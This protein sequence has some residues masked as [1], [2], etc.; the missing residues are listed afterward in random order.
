MTQIE[1]YTGVDEIVAQQFDWNSPSPNVVRA[2]LLDS[3]SS[4]ASEDTVANLAAFTTLGEYAGSPSRT[5]LADLNVVSTLATKTVALR[6]GPLATLQTP[7]T[8]ASLPDNG[9][10]AGILVYLD[11][12]GSDT[13]ATNIPLVF[14]DDAAGDPGF[15]QTPDGTDFEVFPPGIGWLS[16]TPKP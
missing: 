6:S 8:F 11:I 14:Y 9:P 1:F 16:F 13:D 4:V 5:Q 10:V 3:T 7:A 12:G 2:I 15:P